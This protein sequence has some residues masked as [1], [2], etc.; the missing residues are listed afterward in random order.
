MFGQSSHFQNLFKATVD[1]NTAAMMNFMAA[2]RWLGAR[3]QVLGSLVVLFAASFVVA[4]NDWL[5]LETGI[6]AMLIIWSSNFTIT[7]SFFSQAISETEAYLTSVERLRDLTRLPQENDHKTSELVKL[8]NSWPK[9][10]KLSFDSVCLR[11]R[12]GL[13]YALNHLTF[14]VKA[15]QRIGVVGRTGAG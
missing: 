9:E 15:G 13:P 4:F 1:K 14:D 12:P 10:G 7:L 5:K 8:P 3:F 11:Y 6:I 2:Q